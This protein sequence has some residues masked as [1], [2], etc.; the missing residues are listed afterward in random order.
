M[1]SY[2]YCQQTYNQPPSIINK[3]SVN[4]CS[5]DTNQLETQPRPLFRLLTSFTVKCYCQRAV[6]VKIYI[7]LS[8][9][10]MPRTFMHWG[11][12]WA[13]CTRRKGVWTDL[14]RLWAPSQVQALFNH[15]WT[16]HAQ[17]IHRNHV[18]PKDGS[19]VCFLWSEHLFFLLVDGNVCV[20]VC[21]Q[22]RVCVRTQC[23]P[24]LCFTKELQESLKFCSELS[25][26]VPG[27]GRKKNTCYNI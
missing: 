22:V 25:L 15:L 21:V 26:S 1:I 13:S 7:N 2:T 16:V 17:H 24:K 11:A 4:T 9:N 3:G 14:H 19:P 18:S 27:R 20:C 6:I 10:S 5:N 8:L 12:F 23:G